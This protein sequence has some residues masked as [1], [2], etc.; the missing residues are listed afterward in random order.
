MR[1]LKAMTETA[2]GMV[3]SGASSQEMLDLILSFQ[4]RIKTLTETCVSHPSSWEGVTTKGESVYIYYRGGV[5]S[6]SVNGECV[7]GTEKKADGSFFEFYGYLSENEMRETLEA[8]FI[9]FEC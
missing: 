1:I 4:V 3:A 2:Q 7:L 5:L 6:V 9:I 8:N